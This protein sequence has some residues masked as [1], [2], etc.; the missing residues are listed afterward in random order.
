[1]NSRGHLM[2][3]RYESVNVAERCVLLCASLNAHEGHLSDSYP[4]PL[5]GVIR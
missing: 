5:T 1:M 3:F 4:S 2:L